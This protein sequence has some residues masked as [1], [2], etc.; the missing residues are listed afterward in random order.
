MNLMSV[1]QAAFC[2]GLAMSVSL[3]ADADCYD[4]IPVSNPDRVYIDHKDGTVTDR[5]TGLMWKQCS[6]G[7]TTT[8]TPCDTGSPDDYTWQE[9]LQHAAAVE[10]NGGFAG[11]TDWRL[12][13]K[14]E[15]ASLVERSCDEPAINSVLFPETEDSSYWTSSPSVYDDFTNVSWGVDFFDGTI[16]GG[17]NSLNHHVRLVRGGQ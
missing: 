10:S 5:R 15:L 14:N 11:Y 12:P 7:Q 3:S 4:N 6:E 2:I 17:F 16:N 13:N 9:A 8:K 1:G